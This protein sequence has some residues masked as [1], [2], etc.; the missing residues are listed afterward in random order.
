MGCS[1]LKSLNITNFN[2]SKTTDMEHLFNGCIL[3]TSIDLSKFDTQ[4]SRQMHYMFANCISLVSLD[5]SNFNTSRVNRMYNMFSNCSSLISLDLSNFNTSSVM[6]MHNMFA[7]CSSLSSLDLSNFNTSAVQYMHNMFRNCSSLTSL[8]LSNFNT[9]SATYM[10]NMFSNCSSLTSLDLSN[11]NTSGVIYMHNMFL[12]CSSL[13]SLDL[14]NFNTSKLKRIFSMF[15]GCINLEYIDIKNFQEDNLNISFTYSI[16]DN[17]PDNIIICIN[18]NTSI[19]LEEIK[20][21]KCYTIAC[22]S[23]WKLVHKKIA[24]ENG[25]CIDKC[26]NKYEYNGKCYENC[27]NGFYDDNNI[28][29]CKCELNKC[30]TCPKVSL[31][32]GLCTKCNDNFYSMEND[33]SNLGKYINCYS[34]IERYYLDKGDQLFKK[35]YDT[36]ESCEINGSPIN[37]NCIKCISNFSLEIKNNNYL[38]CYKDNN[39][40]DYFSTVKDSN[41]TAKETNKKLFDRIINIFNEKF[42]ILKEEEKIIEGKDDFYF[43][44]TSVEDELN[45][46][47]SNNNSNKFSKIDLGKCED[48][49]REENNINGNLSLLILKYEKISNISIDRNL[50][51]EVYEPINKT[52]LNISVCNNISIDIYVPVVLNEQFLTIYNQ[53]KD[54][55]YDL[56]DNKSD[57]YQDICIPYT[58]PEGTDILLSDRINYYFKN[59][60]T[61]CQPNC[62]FSNYSFEK[63]QLK[64]QCDIKSDEI[65]FENIK[66]SSKSVYKSFYDVLK[67]SNYKVLKCYKLAFSLKIFKNNKGNILIMAFIVIF[68]ISLFIY[69]IKGT[70][71]FQI[72][73]SRNIFN[74]LPKPINK[75]NIDSIYNENAF[76]NNE[77]LRQVENKKPIKQDKNNEAS[78]NIFIKKYHD[79]KLIIKKENK[80]NEKYKKFNFPHK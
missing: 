69:F 39:Y 34:S 24:D 68:L 40:L 4:K 16:F 60:Q 44:L 42:D 73:I 22:P 72:D 12:N 17:V 53:I 52:R 36:C 13:S 6:Y 51:F 35:C 1:S 30:Y 10:H 76:K 45:S 59:E 5:L 46:L 32:K 56:F 70:T 49:L 37:H 71:S 15:E 50:Q 61:Q 38:N 75:Q 78:K 8:D 66:F 65:N 29:T 31:S 3:L 41:L 67:Y 28:L 18:N 63:Q 21:L 55:G 62:H 79:K 20:K 57:F 26:L 11:F 48:I 27:L 9:S 2:T 25:Q 64:C 80:N 23:N 33:P 77:P 19:I 14:S 47:E 43:Q 58:T 74:I 7:N 54:L